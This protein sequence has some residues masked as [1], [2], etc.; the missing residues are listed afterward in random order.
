MGRKRRE[1]GHPEISSE[2]GVQRERSWESE[3]SQPD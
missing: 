1:K 3:D 2:K